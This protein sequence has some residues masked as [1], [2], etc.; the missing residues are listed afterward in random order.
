MSLIFICKYTNRAWNF[1]DLFPFGEAHDLIC[2]GCYCA[3]IFALL[4]KLFQ[5]E[6]FALFLTEGQAVD[7][8][9]LLYAQQQRTNES[10]IGAFT[11]LLTMLR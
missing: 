5:R 7:P 4:Q 6:S 1:T 8:F 11:F 2:V 10:S 3:I 9:H